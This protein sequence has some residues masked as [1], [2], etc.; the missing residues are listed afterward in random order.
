LDLAL[1][2]GEE[3]VVFD[4]SRLRHVLGL[5]T[6]R[7]IVH[8]RVLLLHALQHAS[9]FGADRFIGNGKTVDCDGHRRSQVPSS[10]RIK[11]FYC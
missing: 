8:P 2:F 6:L 1:R 7:S 5:Q 10:L 11:F 4:Q 9:G 3:K